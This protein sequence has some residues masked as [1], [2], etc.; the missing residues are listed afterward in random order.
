VR[1][2]PGSPF[3][4]S[5]APTTPALT[6]TYPL[7]LHDALPICDA[8]VTVPAACASKMPRF[9]PGEMP[10]SSALMISRRSTICP[11]PI[12]PTNLQQITEHRRAVAGEPQTARLAVVAETDRHLC[13]TETVAVRHVQDLEIETEA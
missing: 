12:V 5:S 8:D 3:L 10:R 13:D 9:T 4:L 7:S 6:S 11:P 2:L 1:L